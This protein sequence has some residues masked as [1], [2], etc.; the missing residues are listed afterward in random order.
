ME[1]I[2]KTIKGFENYAVS[3]LGRVRNLNRRRM[4]K[5]VKTRKGYFQI[6]LCLDGKRK[7][8]LVHRL[9]AETFISN[10]DK[11]SDVNHI[12]E[13]KSDNRIENLEWLDHKENLNYGTRTKRMA[14]S[15]SIPIYAIYPDNTDEF[16]LS[17]SMAAKE[18]GLWKTSIVKVLKGKYKTTG[19]LKFEY[20]KE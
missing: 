5:P 6:G 20:V 18:L 19:G 1:E 14:E 10:L 15:H 2:W 13:I 17:I 12:N 8:K 11:N 4:M 3:T 7:W 16:F 9:V